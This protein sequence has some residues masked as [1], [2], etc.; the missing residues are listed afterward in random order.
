MKKTKSGVLIQLFFVLTAS[1]LHFYWTWPTY[2][3]NLFYTDT[4]AQVIPS[5]KD[6]L[7][8]VFYNK[9]EEKKVSFTR[10]ITQDEKGI[11]NKKNVEIRYTESLP[12]EVFIIGL[13]RIPALWLPLLV[14][15][16][17]LFTIVACI[18]ATIRAFL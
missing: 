4:R 8:F 11:A 15:I 13:D 3:F 10:E 14:H 18:R 1:A 17:F 9:F 2:A 7:K 12:N 5:A 6:K 16:L